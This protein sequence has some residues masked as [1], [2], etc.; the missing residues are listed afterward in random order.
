MQLRVVGIF[1]K[2]RASAAACLQRCS[3]RFDSVDQERLLHDFEDVLLFRCRRAIL[4]RLLDRLQ[5][6]SVCQKRLV[7]RLCFRQTADTDTSNQVSSLRWL[8]ESASCLRRFICAVTPMR[9]AGMACILPK[10]RMETNADHRHA[11]STCPCWHHSNPSLSS[12][13]H[14]RKFCAPA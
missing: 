14:P 10:Q 8:S 1:P 9:T 6:V 7:V 5:V 4:Q 13:N 2:Q 12:R 3:C 11:C